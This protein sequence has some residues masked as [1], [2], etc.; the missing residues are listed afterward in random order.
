MIA[1]AQSAQA[2]LSS[3]EEAIAISNEHGFP[4]WLAGGKLIR[5]WCFGALGQPAEGI[6]LILEGIAGIQIMGEKWGV[7]FQLP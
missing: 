6:P 7:P 2:M 3:A 1:G 4:L 5:G